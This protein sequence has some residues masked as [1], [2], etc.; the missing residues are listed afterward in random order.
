MTSS[1]R[2]LV[3]RPA[4][5][6]DTLLTLLQQAGFTALHRPA[7]SIVPLAATL[8]DAATLAGYPI[9]LFVSSNAVRCFFA[10]AP[11]LSPFSRCLAVGPATAS[12]LREAGVTG[13]AP[14]SGFDSETLLALPLL[15]QV[16]GLPILLC[17]G[18]G[19]RPLLATTLRQRGARLHELVLYRRQ[20]RND[21]VWP[22]E[23]LAAVLVTS[24]DSWR[25]LA[26]RVPTSCRVIAGSA[27]IAE[28]ITG[29]RPVTIARSP[30]DQDMLAAT[31][32]ALVGDSKS[33]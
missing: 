28:S 33:S 16:Q 30:A 19:G 10:A 20:C 21:F 23:P 32:L 6:A 11:S 29:A 17:R 7:L 25:C 27:R 26:D 4:G 9:I 2:V 15:Q 8:P 24:V 18:E 12:A 13:L 31:C 1:A 22:C 14:E 3:T 5:Q